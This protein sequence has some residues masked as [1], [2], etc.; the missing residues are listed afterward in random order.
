MK[1]IALFTT[2]AVVS[3]V[4]VAEEATVVEVSVSK[5]GA[6][7][8]NGQRVTLDELAQRLV[9]LGKKD[10]MAT[11]VLTESSETPLEVTT[12]VLDAVRRSGF[13]KIRLRTR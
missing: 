5:E 13:T 4:A 12:A 6:V 3:S 11:V 10:K 7:A 9:V 8:L 2:V 1:S